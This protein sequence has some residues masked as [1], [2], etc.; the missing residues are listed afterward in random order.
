MKLKPYLFTFLLL[1]VSAFTAFGLSYDK[2]EPA[3]VDTETVASVDQTEYNAPAALAVD[4]VEVRLSPIDTSV[5][6]AVGK[7]VLNVHR[8]EINTV[9]E[10]EGYTQGLIKPNIDATYE[11]TS[12]TKGF[13][14]LAGNHFARAD[15]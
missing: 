11:L 14:G 10:L 7:M 8:P 3:T 12:S 2:F 1:A 13:S 9:T 4:V 15:V 6:A 5:P